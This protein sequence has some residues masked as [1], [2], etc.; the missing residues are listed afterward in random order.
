M[1]VRFMVFKD[2][3]WVDFEKNFMDVMVSDFVSGEAIIEM[4]MKGVN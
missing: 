1:W 4:E 2:E 3:M